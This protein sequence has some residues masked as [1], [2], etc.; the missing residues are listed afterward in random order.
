[1]AKYR[2][3]TTRFIDGFMYRV[4]AGQPLPEVTLP[5][6]FPAGRDMEPLDAAARHQVDVYND[7]MTKKAAQPIP[8]APQTYANQTVHHAQ[9]WP[10]SPPAHPPT[11]PVDAAPVKQH[12]PPAHAAPAPPPAKGA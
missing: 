10:N 6:G 11:H 5:D 1:M 7:T 9:V 12:E 8:A 4:D 3:H 2:L